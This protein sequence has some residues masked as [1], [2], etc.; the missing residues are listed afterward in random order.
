MAN[1]S[2]HTS[3]PTGPDPSS[4]FLHVGRRPLD[5]FFNPRSIAVI[6]AT[7]KP[8]SVGRTILWN[9]LSSPFGGTVYPVNR[10][11][12]AVLGVKAYP[13][14]SA[15]GE[16][17]DLAVIVTPAAAAVGIVDE[18]GRAGVGGVIVISAGFK[19]T[20]PDGAAVIYMETIGDA[21]A[22]LSAAREVALTEP[23]I[24]IKPGQTAQAA[25]AAAS[26]A[27]SRPSCSGS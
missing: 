25:K 9:L 24:V 3:P 5:T 26:S 12:P 11:R 6:G 7:E 1:S 18:C 13:R 20:G 21:R 23:I 27:A 4:D 10:T 8:G 14:L 16:P 19:E 17:V 22:F 2:P 15:I